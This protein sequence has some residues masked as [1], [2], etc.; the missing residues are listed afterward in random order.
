MMAQMSEF[1]CGV[2]YRLKDGY[3]EFNFRDGEVRF[4]NFIDCEDVVLSI[5]LITE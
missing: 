1:L 5:E 3:F 2:S 4:R